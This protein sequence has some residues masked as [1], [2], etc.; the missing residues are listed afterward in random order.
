MKVKATTSFAGADISMF[1]GEVRDI[2][3]DV[4]APLLECGYL[5]AVEGAAPEEEKEPAG[6]NHAPEEEKEVTG[7]LDVAELKKMKRADLD[8]LA[9]DM[10]IE[11]PKVYKTIGELAEAVA[12]IEVKA[13]TEGSED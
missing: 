5:T 13:P 9:T 4:A 7:H 6:E 1:L 11:D 8:A 3:E 2:H 10:G 12:A